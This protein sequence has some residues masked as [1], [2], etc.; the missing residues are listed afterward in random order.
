MAS[1]TPP[2]RHLLA[3]LSQ[4][5]YQ[6]CYFSWTVDCERSFGLL[7]LFQSRKV[8]QFNLERNQRMWA[9]CREWCTVVNLKAWLLT[10]HWTN[11]SGWTVVIVVFVCSLSQRFHGIEGGRG[12][13]LFLFFLGAILNC[14]W[15]DIEIH[16]FFTNVS[17]LKKRWYSKSVQ[18]SWQCSFLGRVCCLYFHR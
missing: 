13:V 18:L 10:D 12:G 11:F 9:D 4:F 14:N 1:I 17:L 7:V 15:I 6:A 2:T 16:V 5:L 3:S 8:V